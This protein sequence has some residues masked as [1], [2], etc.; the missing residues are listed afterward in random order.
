[1]KADSDIPRLSPAA[2]MRSQL[3]QAASL[4][5]EQVRLFILQHEVHE[6]KDVVN[7]FF[8]RLLLIQEWLAMDDQYSFYMVVYIQVAARVTLDNAE[9]DEWFVVKVIHFDREAKE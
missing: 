3:E 4:K 7:F 2:S 5:G 8:V 9:K 1:M 6:E